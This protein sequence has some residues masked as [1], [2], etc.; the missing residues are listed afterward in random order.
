MAKLYRTRD[1]DMLDAI[2]YSEYGTEQAVTIVLD[3]NP[4]LAENGAKFSAGVQI[5]LPDYNPPAEEDEDVL[6]S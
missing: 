6:W 1:G 5:V 3:A 4:R 2:C